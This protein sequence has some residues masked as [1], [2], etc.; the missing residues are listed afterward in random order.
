MLNSS[1]TRR[2]QRGLS[3]VEL[4]VGIA[5]GLVIV[6]AASVVMTTQLFE[7]RRLV[8]ETQMQQDLRAATD[9]MARELRRVDSDDE[10]V[11]LTSI[12]HPGG[13][14][15]VPSRF[16]H[17]LVWDSSGN[18]IEFKYLPSKALVP[19]LSAFKLEGTA[20]KTLIGGNLQELTDPNIMKVTAMTPSITND[21]SA[22]I[23]LPCP[24]VCTAPFPVAGDDTSCW[25]R[26]EVRTAKIALAAEAKLD[27]NVKREISSTV[28]LRNDQVH[29]SVP[30]VV[31][32]GAP[33]KICPA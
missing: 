25:P 20:V 7:N 29:F 2:G 24:D 16:A 28:R 12:W 32:A 15:P 30:A 13:G 23:V 11:L 21:S 9:L 14:E 33:A 27:S 19:E 18:W 31:P 1:L 17:E 8:A 3:L 6:A 5:I 4:M 22:G 10:E 26:Y